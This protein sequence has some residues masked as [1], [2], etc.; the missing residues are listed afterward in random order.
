MLAGCAS[1]DKLKPFILF[2]ETPHSDTVSTMTFKLDVSQRSV[3]AK[4]LD[5]V[6]ESARL[7][8]DR[9]FNYFY[10]DERRKYADGRASFQITYYK[11]P[12]EGIPVINPMD[13][14]DPT[15]GPDPMTS[16]IDAKGMIEGCRLLQ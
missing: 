15:K 5:I 8:V 7:T 16:A 6:C 3:A 13:L 14:G 1:G 9:G 12:P 11:S 10:I 2:N 4:S